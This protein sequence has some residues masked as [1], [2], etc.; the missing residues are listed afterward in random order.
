MIQGLGVGVGSVTLHALGLCV[1][2]SAIFLQKCYYAL[3]HVRGRFSV[4]SL[5]CLINEMKLY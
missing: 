4:L 1:F 5:C 2:H 3:Q